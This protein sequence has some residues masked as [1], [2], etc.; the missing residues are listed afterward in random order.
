MRRRFTTQEVGWT[1][2]AVPTTIQDVRIYHGG[3]D[4]GMSQQFLHRANIVARQ[5][6]IVVASRPGI[7]RFPLPCLT[8]RRI[9]VNRF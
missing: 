2:D 1:A 5:K 7:K 3:A 9:R 8:I 6:Q 4:V